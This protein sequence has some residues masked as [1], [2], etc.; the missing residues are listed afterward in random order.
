MQIIAPAG[1]PALPAA[2][3]IAAPMS[4]AGAEFAAVLAAASPGA[5]AKADSSVVPA[6]EDEGASPTA[7]AEISGDGTPD[8]PTSTP[9]LSEEA[10][11]NPSQSVP[12]DDEKPDIPQPEITAWPPAQIEASKFDTNRAPQPEDTAL[13]PTE[14]PTRPSPQGQPSAD[15]FNTMGPIPITGPNAPHVAVDSSPHID[16]GRTEVPNSLRSV[17]GSSELPPRMPFVGSMASPPQPTSTNPEIQQKSAKE[18][19]SASR[20][21][22]QSA[23][24]PSD[25]PSAARGSSLPFPEESQVFSGT[26]L[27]VPDKSAPPVTSGQKIAMNS[28]PAPTTSSPPLQVA[29]TLAALS[30]SEPHSLHSSEHEARQPS[31]NLLPS[32]PA[33]AEVDARA[34]T[35]HRAVAPDPWPAA[36]QK[37]IQPLQPP[38]AGTR[39]SQTDSRAVASPDGGRPNFGFIPAPDDSVSGRS[40]TVT[41]VLSEQSA[42]VVSNELT[43]LAH[44]SDTTIGAVR[45]AAAAISD[46][47]HAAPARAAEPHRQ[48]ADAIVRTRDGMI[49]VLLDPVELG[50]VTVLLGSE[51]HAGRLGLLVERPETLDLLRRHTDDLIRDL[52]DNGMPDARMDFMRQDSSGGQNRGQQ[53]GGQPGTSGRPDPVPEITPTPQTAPAVPVGS[54]RLDIR[55]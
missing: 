33:S 46:P 31:D 27:T 9:G 43:D 24:Q 53:V 15:G 47:L 21:G 18:A 44:R 51:N 36:R 13:P 48:I 11:E 1:P 55:L 20:A 14:I 16:G 34:S 26:H 28:A 23:P 40:L 7:D 45:H 8:S 10:T 38:D 42:P 29:A 19:P 5:Q 30:V 32:L 54:G 22:L 50:R 39:L 41:S 35:Q 12:L 2:T 17:G 52:R 3:K 49:E 4:L 25:I 6:I 37:R